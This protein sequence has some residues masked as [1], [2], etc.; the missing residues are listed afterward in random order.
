MDIRES[1]LEK[2]AEKRVNI[3]K[4]FISEDELEKAV[5]A[6]NALNRKLQ[7]VGKEWGGKKE[8]DK[9]G[10]KTPKDTSPSS[11]EAFPSKMAHEDVQKHLS[12]TSTETLK[13]FVADKTRDPKLVEHAK[14]ELEVRTQ[15]GTDGDAKPDSGKHESVSSGE[16]QLSGDKK[17]DSVKNDGEQDWKS[18]TGKEDK[19][20]ALHNKKD[21]NKGDDFFEAYYEV[22]DSDLDWKKYL[23]DIEEYIADNN[24][25]LDDKNQESDFDK[26]PSKH[27]IILSHLMKKGYDKFQSDSQ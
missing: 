17:S 13:K 22:S 9:G 16:K 10:E 15:A 7:R 27:R 2:Q 18:G 25:G 24:L 8:D 12:S 6:D 1:I 11:E 14:R 26:L 23:G 19:K 21:F 5:Y 20:P 3:I 4:A